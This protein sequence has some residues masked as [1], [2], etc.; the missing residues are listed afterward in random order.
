MHCLR[1]LALPPPPLYRIPGAI[2]HSTRT[3]AV[4]ARASP[5]TA[6]L[7]WVHTS[8]SLFETQSPLSHK[9]GNSEKN[10][11]GALSESKSESAGLEQGQGVG[12]GEA[13]EVDYDDLIL[14]FLQIGIQL[15]EDFNNRP[16]DVNDL[17]IYFPNRTMYLYNKEKDSHI[18]LVGT[19]H[20]DPIS[21]K[22]INQV[23]DLVQP[24]SAFIELSYDPFMS[25]RHMGN[26]FQF[27]MEKQYV[28]NEP[29]WYNYWKKRYHFNKR[30]KYKAEFQK[31]LHPGDMVAGIEKAV[32]IGARVI[33]GDL[34]NQALKERLRLELK[35]FYPDKEFDLDRVYKAV[36]WGEE[37]ELGDNYF[38][39]K[40]L[41]FDKFVMRSTSVRFERDVVFINGLKNK[42]QG[43]RVV[44]VLGRGHLE[45]IATYW[46]S[47]EERMAD[48]GM[49]PE[50]LDD[51]EYSFNDH[52]FVR[53]LK[54][55]NMSL[56][57]LSAIYDVY[58]EEMTA[59]PGAKAR[60]VDFVQNKRGGSK[61]HASFFKVVK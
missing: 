61:S 45:G 4:R 2:R 18:F 10:K 57:K 43:K 5:A 15:D 29:T 49:V 21:V 58:A 44:A 24:N 7:R 48:L 12:S 60:M 11:D 30:R 47:W 56:E 36:T 52:A 50:N 37:S 23:M 6:A 32:Q 55:P 3:G 17:N 40:G 27:M 51:H 53:A 22:T 9:P 46:D 1:G 35:R 14:K 13:K 26:K 8:K 42:C 20:D 34:S 16:K 19:N 33:F 31:T 41:D 54:N 39:S 38:N 25:M 28:K 59:D